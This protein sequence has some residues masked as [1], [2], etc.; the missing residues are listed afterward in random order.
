MSKSKGKKDKI[1]EVNVKNEDESEDVNSREDD[2]DEYSNDFVSESIHS[3]SLRS[4]KGYLQSAQGLKNKAQNIEESGYS[5]AFEDISIGQSHSK[6]L[7][8]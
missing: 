5:E 2:I 3:E 8:K 7:E 6:K 1:P 4:E